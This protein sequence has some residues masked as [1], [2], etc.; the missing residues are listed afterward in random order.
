MKK[1]FIRLLC[2]SVIFFSAC[3]IFQKDSFEG[4]WALKLDGAIKVSFD[5]RIPQTNEFS[6]S[7]SVS[8]GG[9]NYDITVNGKVEKDGR[10]T[11]EITAGGQV[12]GDISGV[13]TFENGTGK[14]HASI[15]SGDWTA[16]KK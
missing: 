7:N 2:I 14:W 12:L 4:E 11:A 5:F 9:Q 15:L 1:Y 13:M 3:S 16:V 6:F 10:V 8:Y